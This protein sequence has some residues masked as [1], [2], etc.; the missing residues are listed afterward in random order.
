MANASRRMQSL[1]EDLLMLSRITT[2]AQPFVPVNLV[3]ITAEVLSDL[4]V[5]LQQTGGQVEIHDLPTINA[6]PTQIRQLLQNLIGNA[7]K[8][9]HPQ[10]SPLVKISSQILPKPNGAE[11][12]QIIIEDNGIGFD[13]KYLDR[14]FNVFQ[15]LHARSVYEGTGIGLAICRK[16]VERHQ[17]EIIAYS[18]PGH[19]AKFIVTL[20]LNII[21]S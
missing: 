21:I 17:G 4:E 14:I 19:G 9:H 6:D 1:I 7:L 5:C 11:D 10:V 8:F 16:I 20:P 2:R 12:C 3:Q 18:Q 15:R 13:E